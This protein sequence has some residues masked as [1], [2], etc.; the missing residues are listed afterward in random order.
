MN[1]KEDNNLVIIGPKI[2]NKKGI[3]YKYRKS[4]NF[5]SDPEFFQIKSQT[6]NMNNK[7]EILGTIIQIYQS[8]L[9]INEM[10]IKE[11]LTNI[12]GSVAPD[13]NEINLKE[14]LLFNYRIKLSDM[15]YI[16]TPLIAPKNYKDKIC[17]VEYNHQHFIPQDYFDNNSKL[18]IECFCLPV[19]SFSAKEKKIPE[20]KKGYIG[21]FL[22]PVKI[23]YVKIN[24]EDIKD[25]KYKYEI[26]NNG[27]PE[28]NCFLIS[29]G[30]PDKFSNLNLKNIHGKDYSIGTDSYIEQAIDKTF[31]DKAKKNPEIPEEV[32]NK[33]FNICF[34]SETEKSFLFRPN[35]DMDENEFIRDISNQISNED[36]QKIK[37]NKKYYFLPFCEKYE[38]EEALYKSKNLKC[39]SDEHKNNIIE[40][41]KIGD[42]I[43]KVPEIKVKLLSKNLGVITKPN[44][45]LSQ[46]I[47]STG[48]EEL[49]P[50]ESINGGGEKILKP[51]SEN[52]FNI[53][54]MKEMYNMENLENYQWKSCIKFNNELQMETFKKLLILARQNIN[55]K[56]KNEY[57]GNNEFNSE[58]IFEF[59]NQKKNEEQSDNLKNSYAIGK[60]EKKCEMNVEFIDFRD[61]FQLEK[62]PT[63]LE[64]IVF[65]EGHVEKAILNL[66]VDY[67]NN[68]KNSL[69]ENEEKVKNLYYKYNNPG[70]K[71]GKKEYFP[72][73]V[74]LSKKKI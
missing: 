60:K 5:Y 53:F 37:N 38:G 69:I 46:L 13:I 59:D 64:I 24:Y 45:L 2:N 39:L 70:D 65:I 44:I 36:L 55:T 19:V 43:Y 49:L 74:K 47:Y 62:D 12:T 26:E 17:F 40:N 8:E 32:K 34:D 50:L 7:E 27:I 73:K 52:S 4:N 66:F 16:E 71:K 6:I 9:D 20:K 48:E 28:P 31:I 67:P 41:Y 51:I 10:K 14:N 56:N 30:G 33:Y 61:D 58:K 63:L 3:N 72:K 22:S 54:D 11:L 21:N 25:G 68:F 29:D 15:K 35:E 18:I 23:G 57:F 1:G 42:W